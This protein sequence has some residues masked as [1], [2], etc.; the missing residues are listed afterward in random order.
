MKA[1]FFQVPVIDSGQWAEEL[2]RFLATHRVSSMEQELVHDGRNSRWAFSIVYEEGAVNKASS[3]SRRQQVD[4]REVLPPEQFAAFA[5][6]RNLRKRLA[7]RDGVPAYAIFTNEQL[8]GMVR[9]PTTT[10]AELAALPGVSAGRADKYGREFV[11][12]LFAQGIASKGSTPE[13]EPSG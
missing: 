10:V 11:E 9:K 4:Y 6:L 12:L 3:T 8:A 2:N 13:N 7:E 1:A 5:E